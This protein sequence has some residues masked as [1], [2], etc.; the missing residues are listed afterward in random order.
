VSVAVG[1]M[2]VYSWMLV[3]KILK[4]KQNAESAYSFQVQINHKFNSICSQDFAIASQNLAFRGPRGPGPPRPGYPGASSA[5][6]R[7]AAR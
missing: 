2:F 3:T 4:K 5:T 7:V 1:V 6:A